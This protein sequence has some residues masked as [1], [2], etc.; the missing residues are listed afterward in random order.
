MREFDGYVNK[1]ATEK[2]I[3]TDVWSKGDYAF[4]TGTYNY[5]IIHPL[6]R[7][8]FKAQATSPLCLING[9]CL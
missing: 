4:M 6:R 3:L 2:K 9:L 5:G 7:Y 8:I 1:S